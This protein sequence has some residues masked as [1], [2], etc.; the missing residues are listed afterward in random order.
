M[1]AR[2]PQSFQ[3]SNN[4][5]PASAGVATA[6][7]VESSRPAQSQSSANDGSWN[8]VTTIKNDPWGIAADQSRA[9]AA[10]A[11]QPQP[12]SGQVVES[13]NQQRAGVGADGEQAQVV[14][15]NLSAWK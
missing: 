1:A 3:A 6:A 7:P 13:Q 5:F 4:I 8:G 12:T 9:A 11:E 10:A 15:R 14:K 2:M